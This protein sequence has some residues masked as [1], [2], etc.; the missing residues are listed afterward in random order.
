MTARELPTERAIYEIG[1]W[2]DGRLGQAYDLIW[3]VIKDRDGDAFK[4]P[5]LAQIESLDEQV[6]S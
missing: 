4:H 6:P 1:G 3:A 2:N 5:L